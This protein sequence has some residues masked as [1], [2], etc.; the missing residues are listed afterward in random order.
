[1][2]KLPFSDGA[3]L[4]LWSLPLPFP[5]TEVLRD[6]ADCVLEAEDR[7]LWG[8]SA[9]FERARRLPVPFLMSY[10]RDQR[11]NKV[12]E[13]QACETVRQKLDN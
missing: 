7:M 2:V 4:P 6:R 5:L 11:V 9:V 10:I 13:K 3:S 8:K 12:S 1:M